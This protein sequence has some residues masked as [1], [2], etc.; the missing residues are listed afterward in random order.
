MFAPWMASITAAVTSF[1]RAL[2]PR[3][4]VW[5]RGSAVT[6]SIALIS[7]FAPLGLSKML[8]HHHRRPERAD[9]VGDLSLPMMSKAEPWI[10]STSD[11]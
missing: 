2:P 1:V 7:R 8:E 9:R 10:S 4:G 11:G 6:R 3:S 5:K